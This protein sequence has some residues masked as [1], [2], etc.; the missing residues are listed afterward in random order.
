M[1]QPISK[2]SLAELRLRIRDNN[3]TG[4][5]SGLAKS[6]LQANLV[7]LP[8][9]WANEFLLFCQRNPIACPLIGMTE[10][11]SKRLS[12]IGL[13]ID[14][15]RDVPEYHVFCDGEFSCSVSDLDNHWRN[16]LVVFVLG[17]SFSFE[18]AMTQTGLRIRNIEQNCNVSMYDTN[19]ACHSA[20]RFHGNMVVSM[21]P[22]VPSD[23]IR[24]IQVTTRFP[25]AHGAPVHFGQPETIGITDINSPDYGD[26]VEIEPGEVPVFW[27]CGVTPQN[28]MRASKP[29]FCITHAPGKMLITDRLN[30]EFA[31]L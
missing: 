19:I 10:A 2:L 29:P 8:E 12:E 11:G 13:D 23:A 9:A 30:S 28:V 18:D 14:I 21:R 24:A 26:S 22:F 25:K 27:A 6:Y 16:D 3:Y 7:I 31:F 17:C 1:S 4:Y 20:G 15:T 5:T